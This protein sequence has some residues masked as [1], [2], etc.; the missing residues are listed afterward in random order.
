MDVQKSPNF[1]SLSNDG[2]ISSNVALEGKARMQ[3]FC[4]VLSACS[5][6]FKSY[7]NIRI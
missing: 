2:K 3:F 7:S 5:I 4:T 6:T 1:I